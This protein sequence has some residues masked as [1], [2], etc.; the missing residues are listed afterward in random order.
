[1]KKKLFDLNKALDQEAP[2]NGLL[3]SPKIEVFEYT[4][5]RT[6]AIK[7]YGAV[8]RGGKKDVV[9]VPDGDGLYFPTKEM[10]EEAARSYVELNK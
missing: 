6:G 9:I 10:A 1:M 7:G 5:R 3:G 4:N 8:V 2:S